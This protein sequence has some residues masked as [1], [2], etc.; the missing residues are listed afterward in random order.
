M[1]PLTVLETSPH[2]YAA[3]GLT[4]ESDLEL[5]GFEPVAP[6]RPPDVRVLRT[7]PS[8]PDDGGDHVGARAE[9]VLDASVWEGREIRVVANPEADPLYVSAVVTGELFSVLLR[10]RGLLVLHG[11]GAV[12]NGR[13]VG[14]VGDSGWGKSTLA[15]A[16]VARGWQ[17]VTDDLLVVD[18]DS[19]VVRPSHASMRLSDQ[20]REA[21]GDRHTSHGQAHAMTDKVRM[22][23]SESF[24]SEPAPL[25]AVLVL[26]PRFSQAAEAV[27]ISRREAVEEYVTHTRGRRL[28][29][30]ERA[31]RVHLSQCAELARSVPA[32]SLRRRFGLEHVGALCDAVEGAVP[33]S[34]HR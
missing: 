33:V 14:L 31:R 26:D 27:P 18:T 4:I 12:R 23:L 30:G 8:S 29:H 21:V 1:A 32:F 3:F 16:L 25:G 2:S 15:A 7:E 22:D 28:L 34:S 10:Q 9:G 20:S 17:L 5:S 11:S 19:A 13:A 24:S 6:V